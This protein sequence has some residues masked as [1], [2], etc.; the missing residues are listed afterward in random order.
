MTL[1]RRLVLLSPLLLAACGGDEP[2]RRDFPPLHYDY[3]TTL[4]LNVANLDFSEPPPPGP[5][6]A[7]NPAPLA[8]AL[9]QMGHDRLAAG[10]SSG[11]AVFTVDQAL[12]TQIPDGLEGVVAVRLDVLSPD[13]TRA[14]FAEA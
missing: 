6:E 9:L 8:Q 13:G 10:G 12:I 1:P 2:V 3:L 7:I 4:R 14:G 11:R 5:L